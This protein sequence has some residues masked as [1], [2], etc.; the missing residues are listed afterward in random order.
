ME[1]DGDILDNFY[2]IEIRYRNASDQNYREAFSIKIT[3]PAHHVETPP[4]SRHEFNISS[5][6]R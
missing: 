5:T 3:P 6:C 1:Y 4:F 2:E